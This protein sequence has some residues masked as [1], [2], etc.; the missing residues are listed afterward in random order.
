MSISE[1]GHTLYVS[2]AGSRLTIEGDAI[3]CYAADSDSWHR[4]PLARVESIVLIGAVTATND[5]L[6]RCAD[7]RRPVH[8][9]TEFGRPRAILLGPTDLC[10]VVRCAQHRAHADEATRASLASVLVH[11]KIAAMTAQLRSGAHNATGHDRQALQR[12]I[13][14]LEELAAPASRPLTRQ[15]A[16]GLE[17][18]ATRAYYTGLRHWL[19][20]AQGIEVPSTRTRHP[21]TDPVNATL[22]FAYALTRGAVH[23]A[24]HA[25][26]LDPSIGFLHG[27]R[28]GQP[29]L[30][31]DLMEELR[32]SADRV[33][34]NLFNK[35][36]LRPEHYQAAVS[37]ACQ[38]TE[39][40][41]K[42]LFRAWH[43]SR[44]LPRPH[45]TLGREV[46]GALIPHV[47]AR[48]MVRHLTGDIP[49]YL[50]ATE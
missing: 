26:G 5:L 2:T 16:L 41:R 6:I 9:L 4:L 24:I 37:G 29:A 14:S 3:R 23:G 1:V 50:P 17:G 30:V 49:A 38:L 19:R 46:P 47:Q 10:G 42:I 8:W 18:A 7:D 44:Q 34:V 39:E 45:K 43:D 33:V 20:P 28:D 11:G 21:A 22:S 36:Q 12:A 31:L 48:I 32:P 25:A 27:D 13:C 40:G 35:K 15:Q